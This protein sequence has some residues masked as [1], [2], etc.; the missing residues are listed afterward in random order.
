MIHGIIFDMDGLLI[1]SEPLWIQAERHAF[2][3]VGIELTMTQTSETTGLRVDEV[4]EHWY[5]QY[6]WDTSDYTKESL[7]QEI[8]EEVKKLI[9]EE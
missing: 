2:Q 4:V 8:V 5:L 6:P 3:K 9:R 1:D 7:A